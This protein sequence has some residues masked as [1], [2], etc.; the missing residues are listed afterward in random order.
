MNQGLMVPDRSK[1]EQRRQDIRNRDRG[2]VTAKDAENNSGY[3]YRASGNLFIRRSV[4]RTI[5]HAFD[6]SVRGDIKRFSASA[7]SRMRSY[8]RECMAEYGFMVTLTYPGFFTSNGQ[9]S[10]EHLRRMLQEIKREAQ[11]CGAD[12]S[13]FSLFW[14]LEFQGRGAPHY[15]IFS[16]WNPNKNWLSSRWYEIVNSEDERHLRAG[17]NIEVLR[18]G[19]AGTI[20]YAAKY[21]N[22]AEQKDVPEGYENVGRFW[23]ITG[24]RYR[25]S[26]STFVSAKEGYDPIVKRIVKSISDLIHKAIAQGY[27]EYIVRE[28]DVTVVSITNSN[29]MKKLRVQVHRLVAQTMVWNDIFSDCEYSV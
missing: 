15:H 20:S 25:L 28:P 27:G 26:A 5:P 16:T 9:E 29:L 1:Y 8:L 11:R 10:K 13:K 6:H 18:A 24:I 12:M 21:A 19:R 22:K 2:V 3:I 14:F 7:G 4:S 17:T 23:G